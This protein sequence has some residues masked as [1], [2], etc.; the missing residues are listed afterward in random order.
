MAS[1]TDARGKKL[2]STY[3]LIGR[4]TGLYADSVTADKQLAGWTFDS[5]AKGQPTASIRYAGG[6]GGQAYTTTVKGYD[7]A[8]RAT[9]SSITIP[10]PE[11]GQAA[12]APFTY[13]TTAAYDALTGQLTNSRLPALGGLPLD[14]LSYS[15]ND[16]GQL[17]KYAGAT[18]YDVQTK[19]DAY[20]RVL[21][22]TV[23][24][25]ATQVVITA[26]YDQA[27]GRLR[28]QFLDK[29]TSQTGAVQQTGY[30]YNDAGRITSVTTIPDNTPTATDRQ[31]FTYD[32]LGRVTTAWTDTA[33]ITVPPADQGQTQDQGQC[34]STA[35][36]AATVGG[37]NPYWQD[38]TYDI[39]GNRK[40]FTDHDLTGNTTKDTITTQAFPGAGTAN[41]GNGL[42]G[43][44][45]LTSTTTK[46]GAST[47]AAGSNGYDAVGNT[48]S[49]YTSKTGNTGL[50]WNAE[51]KLD[52]NTPPISITGIGGKCLDM[53]SASSANSTPVQIYTCNGT[54][55]QKFALS[56][57]L[58]KVFDKCLTTSGTT[59]GSTVLL[60]PCDA[61]A[62]QTWTKRA[63]GTLYN[64]Q[65]TRCLSVPGNVTT[66]GT[67][68]VLGDCATTVP[69]GQKWTA[70]DQTTSYVYDA[71]GLQLIQ[72]NPGKT[73]IRLGSDQ[74]TYD[75]VA[76]TLTGTRYYPIP[77]GLTMVREGTTVMSIQL[78]DHH[79]TGLL[80]LDSGTLAVSRRASDPFGNP[81]GPQPAP[82]VWD[83]DKGFVGGTQDDK[84][85]LTNLG[86]RQYQPSTGR[87]ITTDPLLVVTDPQ[88]W[89]GYAYSNNDP[90]NLSDPSGLRPDGTCGGNTSTCTPSDSRS[91]A[92][93]NYHESWQYTGNGGWRWQSWIIDKSETAARSEHFVQPY[94]RYVHPRHRMKATGNTL[95]G[96]A[97]SFIA[98][99]I[100]MMSHTDRGGEVHDGAMGLAGVDTGGEE[101]E[102]GNKLGFVIGL[103]SG[104]SGLKIGRF[105]LKTGPRTKP[106][107]PCVR[108]SFLPGTKVLMADGSD[109]N[110]EDVE[111]GDVVLATDPET[112]ENYKKTVLDTIL[113]KDDKDFTELTVATKDGPQTIVATDT[114][115]FWVP[116]LKEWVEAGDLNVGTWLHSSTGDRVEIIALNRYTK[117]Q[118][119]HDL[120]V[121]DVHTYYVLAGRAPV[122]VHNTTGCG[123]DLGASW[124]AA[125][126][127][128]IVGSS[129]CEAC[130]VHIQG[131]LG[132]GEVLEILPQIQGKYPTLPYKGNEG[133]W[134]NHYAVVK[135]GRVFDNWTGRHGV[136]EADYMA[137]F[138]DSVGAF[139]VVTR[140][141]SLKLDGN[142]NYQF[143]PGGG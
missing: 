33:G 105:G 139:P 49:M 135:D 11:V 22:S 118:R 32:S 2:V 72:R 117:L 43:P 113:T 125:S 35:P 21:R 100:D 111:V 143:H 91:G 129:G 88:Q 8:Y 54:G 102:D 3:D 128:K 6:S 75:T 86:A 27:T 69:A 61:S 90:V 57:S 9:S 107:P 26:D 66:N 71:S 108:H 80:S 13:N 140:R 18:T 112:G 45:A 74:L 12:D 17:Y 76:K 126:D 101:Y 77:G 23:N 7:D 123:P 4:K 67:D 29:Q 133:V 85:G 110:I 120:T 82:G 78:A 122:L 42:G 97:R 141:G 89:N 136:P 50:V 14:K 24:P 94:R 25:D 99:V 38:Y 41:N 68:V 81:R 36:T 53:Q 55:A 87:F 58:L 48:T 5:V 34:T 39:T 15:Y 83:G 84:T 44:H 119:T 47:T 37:S 16:Y 59:A 109:K 134:Y 1:T 64:A 62:S 95:A 98:P 60:Q 130:A 127:S 116:E 73:I 70:T 124:K 52:S 20:G 115:P 46:T 10:G 138:S 79:G 132:G 19:Y 121:D 93:V 137:R 51:G 30:T 103:L 114:H 142:G 65:S 104:R 56:G 92:T 63:D 28:K 96:V 31:C 131:R 106:L 40:T